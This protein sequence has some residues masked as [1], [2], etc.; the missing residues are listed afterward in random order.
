MN[1]KLDYK[2]YAL[3]KDQKGLL[4]AIAE[5]I[6]NLPDCYIDDES[7]ET[8]LASAK[9]LLRKYTS[10][11]KTYYP[12]PIINQQVIEKHNEQFIAR[13]IKDEIFDDVNGRSLDEE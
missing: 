4:K 5:E 8:A 13:H 9:A 10:Y 12:V 1:T 2:N 7:I 11:P 3:I 6:A